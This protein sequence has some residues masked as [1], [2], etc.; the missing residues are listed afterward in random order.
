[1]DTSVAMNKM[2]LKQIYITSAPGKIPFNA[3]GSFTEKFLADIQDR[4][5][6]CGDAFATHVAEYTGIP[7]A[8]VKEMDAK[9]F[10][11]QE[12]LQ[13]GLVNKIMDHQQFAAYLAASQTGAC[14]VGQMA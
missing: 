8:A 1:M 3:D 7:F 6:M 10:S 12:A 14:N 9:I 2:G 13:V 11:A 4:V 5:D